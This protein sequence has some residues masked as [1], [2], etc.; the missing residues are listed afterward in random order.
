MS[1]NKCASGDDPGTDG[2]VTD[3][4]PSSESLEIRYRDHSGTW[5]RIRFEPR[6]DGPGWYRDEE[7]WTGCHWRPVGRAVVT[8]VWW[9][10]GVGG[11]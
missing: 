11:E 9:Q 8:E 5:R 2:T 10:P 7:E 1:D 4:A 6:P 3:H